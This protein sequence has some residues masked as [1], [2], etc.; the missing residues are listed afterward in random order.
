V[1]HSCDGGSGSAGLFGPGLGLPSGAWKS[2]A[3]ARSGPDPLP[4]LE[5]GPPLNAHPCGLG[6]R[7]YPPDPQNS[8][9]NLSELLRGPSLLNLREHSVR[10]ELEA[11]ALDERDQW[12]VRFPLFLRGVPMHCFAIQTKGDYPTFDCDPDVEV[13]CGDWFIHV[14]SEPILVPISLSV[15]PGSPK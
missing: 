10:I 4:H 3:G 9:A 14:N 8:P 12:K 5:A 1:R 6:T 13:R 2:V 15:L 7:H 11:L